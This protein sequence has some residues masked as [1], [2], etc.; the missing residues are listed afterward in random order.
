MR[1]FAP[2]VAGIGAMSYGRFI[3]YNVV[4]GVAWVAIFLFGGYWFGN[5]PKVREKLH[6]GRPGHHHRLGAADGGGSGAGEAAERNRQTKNKRYGN[7]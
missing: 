2:F 5:L 3:L 1:T 7:Q 6:V 4:G